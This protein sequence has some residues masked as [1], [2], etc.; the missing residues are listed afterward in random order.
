MAK[1]C[2]NFNELMPML[3]RLFQKTERERMLPNSSYKANITL[4][5]SWLKNMTK[6][7]I[8]L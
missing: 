7:K 3:L 6:Y 4:M 2:Q 5:T 8:K 1:L